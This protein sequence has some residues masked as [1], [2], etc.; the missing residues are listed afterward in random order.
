MIPTIVVNGQTYSN[1]KHICDDNP[2]MI[3]WVDSIQLCAPSWF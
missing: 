1:L 2:F 3:A